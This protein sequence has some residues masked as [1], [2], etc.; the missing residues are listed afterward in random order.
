MPI[1][2]RPDPA[3]LRGVTPRDL[4]RVICRAII[5]NDDLE[6]LQALAEDRLDRFRKEAAIVE[7]IETDGDLGPFRARGHAAIAILP[8]WLEQASRSEK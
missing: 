5:R 3:I 7:R 1:P 8:D 2:Q 6:I 4:E